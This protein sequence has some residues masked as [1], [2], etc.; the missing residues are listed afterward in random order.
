MHLD[1]YNVIELNEKASSR[2]TDIIIYILL[3]SLCKLQ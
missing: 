3:L 1:D 2:L